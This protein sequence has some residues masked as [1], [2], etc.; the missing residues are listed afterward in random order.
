MGRRRQSDNSGLILAI[1]AMIIGLAM[2]IY[3]LIK[4]KGPWRYIFLGLLIF[5]VFTYSAFGWTIGAMLFFIAFPILGWVSDYMTNEKTKLSPGFIVVG[6]IIWIVVFV[7]FFA[8]DF[9]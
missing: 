1:I 9:L 6:S 4:L 7:V 5:A 3:T 8:G 2:M